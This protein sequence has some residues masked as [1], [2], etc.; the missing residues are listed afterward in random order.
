M[1]VSIA[2]ALRIALSDCG[3]FAVYIVYNNGPKMLPWGTPESI[4]I[5]DEV[6]L[7]YAVTKYLLCR[8]DFRRLSYSGGGFV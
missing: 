2:K 8:C 3:I 5:G 1:A 4:G 7:F 6:P